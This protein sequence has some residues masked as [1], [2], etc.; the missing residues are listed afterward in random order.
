MLSVSHAISQDHETKGWSN[1]MG[2]SPAL[3]VTIGT[4][5]VDIS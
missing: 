3:Q 4:V 2:G 5:V 1:I